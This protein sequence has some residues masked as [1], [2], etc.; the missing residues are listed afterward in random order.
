MADMPDMQKRK[1]V[2]VRAGGIVAGDWMRDLGEMKEV[3]EVEPVIDGPAFSASAP[4]SVV[5]PAPAPADS[6]PGAEPSAYIVKFT[7]SDAEEFHLY[8]PADVSVSVWRAG[9]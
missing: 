3:A 8:I 9:S 7:A 5:T 1:P 2:T 4:A 6:S